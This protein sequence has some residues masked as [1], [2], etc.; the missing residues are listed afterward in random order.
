MH[1]SIHMTTHAHIH[2]TINVLCKATVHRTAELS[3]HGCINASIFHGWHIR[4][5]AH[6]RTVAHAHT[7]THARAHTHSHTHTHIRSH[8]TQAPEVLD[9]AYGFPSDIWSCGVLMHFVL[10]GDFPFKVGV[11][12]YLV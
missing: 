4:M 2:H 5:H 8:T 10:S 11:Y 1:T 6:T 7:H 9:G 12:F 3:A